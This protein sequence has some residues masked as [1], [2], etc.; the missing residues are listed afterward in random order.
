M[1]RFLGRD[2]R[3]SALI[4]VVA[5]AAAAGACG[6]SGGGAAPI[7][8]GD[9]STGDDVDPDA[10]DID[11][12]PPVCATATGDVVNASCNDVTAAGPCVGPVMV[13]DNSSAPAGGTLVAGTFDLVDRT[14]YTNPGGATGSAGDPLQ[15]TIVLAGAGAS[16]TMDEAV[17]TAGTAERGTL[18]L[19]PGSSLG[20]L[21]A[22]G[23]CPA[24]PGDAGTGAPDAGAG[25]TMSIFYTAADGMLILYRFG[26]TGPVQADTY[27][28]R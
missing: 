23:T 14:I 4:A 28:M 22:T 26:A 21:R 19:V 5:V 13:A 7:D 6:N 9:D 11:V 3:R 1:R 15:Q 10:N 17:L 16:W 20:Q 8:A 24:D 18:A 27:M 2:G 12:P 25:A